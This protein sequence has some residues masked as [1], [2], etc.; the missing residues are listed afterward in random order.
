MTSEE[1]ITGSQET[2][3]R[4]LEN[5]R[6]PDW[7]NPKPSGRYNLVVI[8]AGTAGLT[9]A[10]EAAS[11]G[12]KV[13]LVEKHRMGGKRLN[14]GC[15]PFQRLIKVARQAAGLRQAKLS[16]FRLLQAPEVDFAQVMEDIRRRRAEF[17]WNDS[18]TRVQNLG[19]DV[20]FGE[21]HWLD[22]QTVEVAGARLQFKHAVMAMGSR[23]DIPG[24]PGLEETGYLTPETVFEITQRPVR[25]AV[26]GSGPEGCELAQAFQRLGC[27]VTLLEQ[28]AQLLER[29]DSDATELLRQTLAEEGMEVLLHAKV[30]EVMQ[31][32]KEKVIRVQIGGQERE[33]AVDEIFISTGR[34]PNVEGLNLE[35]AG[36]QYN[37][38]QGVRVNEFLQTTQPHIYAAGNICAPHGFPHAAGVMARIAVRNALFPGKRR[39]DFSRIPRCTCT[40]PEIAQAGQSANELKAAQAK[41]DAYTYSLQTLDGAVFD[42]E[43]RGF[44][45][46]LVR[47]GTDRVLGLT[48]VGSKAGGMLGEAALAFHCG[49]RLRDLAQVIHPCPSQGEALR[50]AALEFL[51]S[52]LTVVRKKWFIRWLAWRR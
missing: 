24:I 22:A 20:Y 47:P 48:L 18:A 8:G 6:P 28:N 17:S 44:V 37:R 3:R 16:G 39:M 29:E 21:A 45:K 30:L 5:V 52:R 33:V 35:S 38:S 26:I 49:M 36:V 1:R 32:G 43:M 13:A 10:L 31:R 4:W 46:A 41:F 14:A 9:A 7:R 42:Y 2:R 25:L 15:V 27:R 23:P 34:R 40:D 11:L 19:V 50:R 12:G 51:R